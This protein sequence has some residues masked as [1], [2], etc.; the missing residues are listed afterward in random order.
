MENLLDLYTDYLLT[1]PTQATCTGLS[2]VLHGQ[3]SHDRFTRLLAGGTIDSQRLWKQSKPLVQ[4]MCEAKDCVVVGIDDT[5][6]EK[7]HSQENELICWHYD[8]TK[9]QTVKGINLLSAVLTT[10]ELV[11]LPLNC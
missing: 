6:Q 3:I 9:G 4:E 10:D 11:S 8:H 7:P 1:T 5:I 2:K